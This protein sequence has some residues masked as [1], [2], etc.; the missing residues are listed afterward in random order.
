ME[1]EM[2]TT[3]LGTV[4]LSKTRVKPS[5]HQWDSQ[6]EHR[7]VKA[8]QNLPAL[9]PFENNAS[10]HTRNI[11][12]SFCVMVIAIVTH[13][14]VWWHK[15]NVFLTTDLNSYQHNQPFLECVLSL[16]N[17]SGKYQL[18][19]LSVHLS[20][21]MHMAHISR[22]F[23]LWSKLLTVKLWKAVWG[24]QPRAFHRIE[25]PQMEKKTW[26]P[27]AERRTTPIALLG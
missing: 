12:C 3:D 4:Q 25:G 2:G 18:K 22:L 24:C 10:I 5:S 6:Q 15:K 19:H 14:K 1:T 17:A 13:H 9:Y 11:T 8:R 26:I 16:R 23:C 20:L 21:C 7:A 27:T